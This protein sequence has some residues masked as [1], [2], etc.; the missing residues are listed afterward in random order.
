MRA[1]A[2]LLLLAGGAEGRLPLFGQTGGDGNKCGAACEWFASAPVDGNADAT[3][4]NRVEYLIEDQGEE[5]VT[6]CGQ[7]ATESPEICGG[8]ACGESCP[9]H[10]SAPVAED[11]GATCGSRV[12]YLMN[13][14]K[15]DAA[16]ACGKIATEEPDKCGGCGATPTPPS[17][18]TP[19]LVIM[20]H[21]EDGSPE[22]YDLP[23]ANTICDAACPKALR[24]NLKP[25]GE[26]RDLPAVARDGLDS[27][28]LRR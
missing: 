11:P 17:T 25:T 15:E 28:G 9:W 20:R 24:N 1:I 16:T 8:C 13:Q 14:E 23:G 10:A 12:A 21:A 2:F 18:C 4:G 7:V 3:C 5:T 19:A 22:K 26:D 6:A 27:H